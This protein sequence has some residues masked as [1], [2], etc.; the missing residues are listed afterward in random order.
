MSTFQK[1][2]R[3]NIPLL[4]AVEGASGSGKTKS[5][6]EILMG[7]GDA[8]AAKSG[9]PARLGVIDTENKRALHYADDY[10]FLHVDM[11]PPFSPLAFG[12][13]IDLGEREGLDALMIDSF[14]HEWAGEGGVKE[15]ADR[16]EAGVPKPGIAN[17]ESWKRDHW[18]VQ[19]VKSPGNWS[20]PKSAIKPGHKWLVAKMLRSPMHIVLCLRSAEKMEMRNDP[21]LDGNGEPQF[22]NGKPKMKSV[23]IAAS[24][25]PLLERW[26]PECEKGLPYEITTS[27]LFLPDAPG[28]PHVRKVQDQ[29]L[30]LIPLD[31]RVSRDVGRALAE[32][33]DGAKQVDPLQREA[34]EAIASAPDLARLERLWAHR[35]MVAFQDLLRAEYEARKLEL[36]PDPEAQRDDASETGPDYD[37]V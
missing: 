16:L 3:A 10:D 26:V 15:W 35:N 19:P 29:H 5:G 13:L 27:L 34:S 17:P 1:A 23:I 2:T 8:I 21:V 30:P 6:L 32:W 25:R 37:G 20:D 7:I 4:I 24:D 33:A 18:Q 22:Y 9:R 31:R 14:S 36:T 11:H 12:D 28:V